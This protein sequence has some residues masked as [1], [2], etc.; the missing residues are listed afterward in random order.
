MTV[1]FTSD[2]H[3]D[4]KNILEYSKRPF[5]NVDEMN[6]ALVK[7]WNDRVQP[8][9][10]VYCL[11]DFCLGQE[12]RAVMFAKRLNGQ[13]YLIYGNH[14]KRLRKNKEFN[15]QWIWQKDLDTIEVGS[16]KIV[17]CH[18][19]MLVWN[20]SHRGYYSLHG[21]SHGSLPEDPHALRTDVGV[22]V[23]NYYP[24]SFEEIQAHMAKKDY[25]PI[26]HHGDRE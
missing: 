22:D 7:N 24:V 19:P 20:G 3:I 4:H 15:A 9:D 16:Q 26:D 11:G 10:R 1:W 6:E 18:F 21:H 23:W 2:L 12:N 13:K 5:K 17:I 8:G 25:Q 14:D